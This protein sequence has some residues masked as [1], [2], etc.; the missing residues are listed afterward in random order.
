[1]GAAL[2]FHGRISAHRLYT[3]LQINHFPR[4]F[5]GERVYTNGARTG[6]NLAGSKY[7]YDQIFSNES[8]RAVARLGYHSLSH[9][10][11]HRH[12]HLVP[13]FQ[14]SPAAYLQGPGATLFSLVR[15]LPNL[16]HVLSLAETHQRLPRSH[17]GLH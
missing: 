16:A 9:I 17:A 13:A 5:V 7:T 12:S 4:R 6:E 1:M 10:P 3:S 14:Q 15:S 2:D 11:P 8:I